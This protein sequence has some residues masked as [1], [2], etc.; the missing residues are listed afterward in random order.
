MRISILYC[1]KKV[2]PLPRYSASLREIS[3]YFGRKDLA[4]RSEW[5]RPVGVTGT[6]AE[7]KQVKR[8]CFLHH[9]GSVKTSRPEPTTGWTARPSWP[10]SQPVLRPLGRPLSFTWACADCDRCADERGAPPARRPAPSGPRPPGLGMS[11][12]PQQSGS[13]S[14]HPSLPR[15]PP[16]NGRRP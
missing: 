2:N 4:T 14:W 10:A 3:R 12:G 5:P 13:G 15:S 6:G 8:A 7:E 1:G 11:C 9:L 16:Q